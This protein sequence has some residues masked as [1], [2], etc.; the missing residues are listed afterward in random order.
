MRVHW[1]ALFAFGIQAVAG[2]AYANTGFYLRGQLGANFAEEIKLSTRDNDRAAYC[3]GFVNP[4]YSEIPACTAPNSGIGA[5]DAW[6]SNFDGASGIFAG[7]ALGRQFGRHLRIELEYFYR[8][9]QVGQTSPLISPSGQPYTDVFG[10]ELPR[11][12]DHL[13]E[14]T[15]HNLFANVYLDFPNTSRFTPYL[16]LGVGVGWTALDHSALWRRSDDPATIA[17]ADRAIEFGLSNDAVEQLR[18]NLAG[19]ESITQDKL[20]DTLFGYQVLAGVDYALTRSLS[21]GLMARWVDFGRFEDGGSY[22]QLRD[23]VSNLRPDLS[24]PVVYQVETPDTSFFAVGL[25]LTF[26]F[27]AAEGL[28]LFF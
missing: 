14:L 10:P 12:E 21:L 15:A 27:E 9:A 19:T 4:Q 5:V 13:N 7:S 1:I 22:K 18:D 11:A 24:E 8:A 20:K 26:R 17:T 16:G 2:T 23:H 25:N 28:P 6:S 3:D